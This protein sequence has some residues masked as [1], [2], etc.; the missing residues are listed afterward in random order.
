[1]M[2]TISKKERS[3]E[4]HH[5]QLKLSTIFKQEVI[6]IPQAFG[7]FYD[8]DGEKYCA[9]SALSKYLGY[10][11]ALAS[12]KIQNDKNVD[13]IE[14]IPN[15]ILETIE[16]FLLYC[17]PNKTLDCFCSSP[18]YYYRYSL[19]SLLIHLNDHHKMTFLQIGGWLE[20]RKM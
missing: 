3:K 4:Q 10:D 9:I 7:S 6:D 14:L 13:P 18:D 5:I 11:I 2:S 8:S 20:S 12:K 17:N 15:T 19:I 16:N 1:M